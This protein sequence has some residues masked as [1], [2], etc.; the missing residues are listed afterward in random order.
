MQHMQHTLHQSIDF[1]VPIYMYNCYVYVLLY[2]VW[3]SD[4]V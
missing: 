3:L 1:A 4:I 2:A